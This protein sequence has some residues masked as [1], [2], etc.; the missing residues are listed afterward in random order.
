MGLVLIGHYFWVQERD[1]LVKWS[2]GKGWA[3]GRSKRGLVSW[4]Y[5]VLE[6]GEVVHVM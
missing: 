6:G 1:R 5:S 2:S 4:V 3:C